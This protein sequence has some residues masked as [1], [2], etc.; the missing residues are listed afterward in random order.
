MDIIE[1]LPETDDR[2]REL[3]V[4]GTEA[5]DKDAFPGNVWGAEAFRQNIINTYDHLFVAVGSVGAAAT[6]PGNAAEE[7]DKTSETELNK[8]AMAGSDNA[9]VIGSDKVPAREPDKILGFAVLRVLDVADI[10]RISVA[11]DSR[12]RGIGRKLLDHML[13]ATSEDGADSVFLEVRASNIPA[14]RMYEQAGFR[15]TEIKKG[16]YDAPRE[17]AV[18]MNYNS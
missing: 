8:A 10:L 13:K 16:Y 5:L 4:S 11:R 14:I 1:I 3:A 18:V 9:A 17:D 7:S 2:L 12:R 15:T 6:E